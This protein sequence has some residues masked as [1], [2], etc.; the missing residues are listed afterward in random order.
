MVGYGKDEKVEKDKKGEK[1]IKRIM[2]EMK[3]GRTE[4]T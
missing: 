3:G 2:K 4:G 1:E